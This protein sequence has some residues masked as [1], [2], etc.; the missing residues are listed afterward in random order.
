VKGSPLFLRVEVLSRAAALATLPPELKGLAARAQEENVFAE[1]LM[2]LP[3]LE[4]IDTHVEL[5]VVCVRDKSNQ[6]MAVVPLVI[7]PLRRGI[8]LKVL[9][10]WSHRYCFLGTPLLDAAAARPVVQTLANWI[11]SGAA[12]AGAIEWLKIS[13]D[14]PFGRLIAEVFAPSRQ[15]ILDTTI[16]RR[17]LLERSAPPVSATSGKH[18]KEHRRL[19]RRLAERGTLS[20]EQLAEPASW[21]NWFEEFLELEAS[22]W[23][24]KEGSAIRTKPEDREFF[25]RVVEGAAES[26]QL[27]M[28]AM[29]LDGKAIAMKLNLRARTVSFSLKIAHDENFAQFSPG[30]LL[31]L[32]NIKTLG[33]EPSAIL[34]MDSCAVPNHSMI[35]RLWEGRRDIAFV[36]AVRRGLLLR[37]FVRLRPLVRRVRHK[38]R[39]KLPAKA[40][41]R[42]VHG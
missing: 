32:F 28:L 2:L 5:T 9:R 6:L 39:T 12:P 14:G 10:S 36:T 27:Q 11:D 30:V 13:W 33:S 37:T 19:E 8:P 34:R 24:G 22:G 31:E 40:A 15:W 23:K 25:R 20:Y 29:R 4:L 38:L 16:V 41:T 17:A 18:A 7:E 35:D 1:A 21:Q 3:A 42:H 26:G